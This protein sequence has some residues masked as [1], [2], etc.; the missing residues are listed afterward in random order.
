MPVVDYFE[1]Q[2]KVVKVDCNQPVDV[3]NKQ[4]VDALAAKGMKLTK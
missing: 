2:H 4:L 3:V 1:D